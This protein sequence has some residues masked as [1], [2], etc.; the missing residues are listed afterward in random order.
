MGGMVDVVDVDASE[1]AAEDV[2]VEANV[3][4]VVE[5]LL[6]LEK[7]ICIICCCR[8]SRSDRDEEGTAFVVAPAADEGGRETVAIVLGICWEEGENWSSADGSEGG[9]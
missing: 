7:N 5:G 3:V 6:L 8:R 1:A 4:D 2:G 9:F